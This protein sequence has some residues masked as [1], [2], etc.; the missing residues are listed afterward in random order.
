[1]KKICGILNRLFNFT[2]LAHAAHN[3]HTKVV[4]LLLAQPSIDIN[5]KDI[6]IQKF[7]KI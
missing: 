3:G 6:Q 5:S 7:H 2:P 1:M 4:E